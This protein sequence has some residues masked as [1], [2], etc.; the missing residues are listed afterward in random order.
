M[1]WASPL[2][3][4]A[5]G[6]TA[7]R[8]RLDVIA[9]NIANADTTRAT[10]EGGRWQPYV[11]RTVALEPIPLRPAN[12][13]AEL[14]A[15][16]GSPARPSPVGTGMLAGGV[17]VRAIERDPSPPKR[18]YDPGHPDADEGGFVAYPNVEFTREMVDLLAAARAYEANATA[19][20]VG[21]ALWQKTLEL[22]RR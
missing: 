8:L 20:A 10:F 14:Q 13:A 3:I 4:S 6:L 2:S 19:F 1:V 5:S 21:K 17:R 9:E 7:G 15:A 11:R 18:V 16:L 22:G 12:F